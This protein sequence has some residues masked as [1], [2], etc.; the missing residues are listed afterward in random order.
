MWLKYFGY[1]LTWTLCT[2]SVWP[3]WKKY[4]WDFS[5]VC[6][7]AHWNLTEKTDLWFSREGK[8]KRWTEYWVNYMYP[9]NLGD[10]QAMDC[11]GMGR[12]LNLKKKKKTYWLILLMHHTRYTTVSQIWWFCL[13]LTRFFTI[14][15][16]N[17]VVWFRIS[18]DYRYPELLFILLLDDFGVWI[19]VFNGSFASNR[20]IK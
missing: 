15:H 1:I 12:Y 17:I 11:L 18:C 6:W 3:P 5:N 16:A 13:L 20:A 19:Q 8:Q 2:F 14:V 4:R 7:T 10:S 9:M